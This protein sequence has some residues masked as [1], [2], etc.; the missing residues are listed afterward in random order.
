VGGA[1]VVRRQPAQRVGAHGA[2]VLL[3]VG[4]GHH[5]V[6][7]PLAGMLERVGAADHRRAEVPGMSDMAQEQRKQR[8]EG[9]E[10]TERER[11]REWRRE[12]GG[13][14]GLLWRIFYNIPIMVSRQRP[15][16]IHHLL[17]ILRCRVRDI[18]WLVHLG[19]VV[20]LPYVDPRVRV[21]P[22]HDGQQNGRY[23]AGYQH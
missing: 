10:R 19:V 23:E 1:V 14:T 8:A 2:H 13:G 17:V 11:S 12:S 4:V 6:L 16:G 21:H 15:G 18:R 20:P 9:R 22:H 5:L 7:L 3:D